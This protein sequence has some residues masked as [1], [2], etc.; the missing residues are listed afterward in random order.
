MEHDGWWVGHSHLLKVVQSNRNVYS[1]K[2]NVK[3]NHF[4]GQSLILFEY[5]KVNKKNDSR[6][7]CSCYVNKKKTTA[8]ICHTQL[9][10]NG[11]WWLRVIIAQFSYCGWPL[12]SQTVPWAAR[13]RASYLR[14]MLPNR[15]TVHRISTAKFERAQRKRS[16]P[17]LSWTCSARNP[18]GNVFG[19]WT[20][21]N[22]IHV[23]EV[24][25]DSVQRKHR[26]L[27]SSADCRI[28]FRIQRVPWSWDQWQSAHNWLRCQKSSSE[29]RLPK[30]SSTISDWLHVPL[31][32]SHRHSVFAV[33]QRALIGIQKNL[34]CRSIFLTRADSCLDHIE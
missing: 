24:C 25:I 27:T 28:N 3:E 18:P 30:S 19:R 31:P 21:W 33:L 2:K 9:F 5:S 29:W 10:A 32:D 11:I 17:N 26:I 13:I 4:T 12:C 1:S 34:H 22:G 7:A 8:T 15:N 14:K 20:N 23:S 16:S 6:L